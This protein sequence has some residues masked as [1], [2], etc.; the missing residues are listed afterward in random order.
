V[1]FLFA[2]FLAD[3]RFDSARCNRQNSRADFEQALQ[4]VPRDERRWHRLLTEADLLV[5]KYRA[6]IQNVALESLEREI[7]NPLQ[8][9]SIIRRSR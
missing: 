7:L 6:A 3:R 5:M 8:I 4:L 1:R 9:S 2:G